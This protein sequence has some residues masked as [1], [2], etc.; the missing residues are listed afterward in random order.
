MVKAVRPATT[1]VA[2]LPRRLGGILA[3]ATGLAIF[4]LALSAAS[5]SDSKPEVKDRFSARQRN[6]WAFHP[7]QTPAV[8]SVQQTGWVRNPIDAFVLAKLEA[9]HLTP[10][11][12]ADRPVLLRRVSLDLI[13]LP[14][15]P[16]EVQA[17][18]HDKS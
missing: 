7:V 8:P 3:G 1:R 16:E 14:P 15:T 9:N 10:S 13:G 4:S 5:V 11:P 6:Y 2:F 18:V 12:E 17:F